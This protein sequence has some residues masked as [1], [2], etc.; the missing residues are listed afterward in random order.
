VYDDEDDVSPQV[1]HGGWVSIP[2][3]LLKAC[4]DNSKQIATFLSFTFCR[5]TVPS[6][7]LPQLIYPRSVACLL[8]SSCYELIRLNGEHKRVH[9]VLTL[10]NGNYIVSFEAD[11]D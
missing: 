7:A 10:S 3:R 11:I 4:L 6:A 2:K 1:Q 9:I 5:L 8:Y